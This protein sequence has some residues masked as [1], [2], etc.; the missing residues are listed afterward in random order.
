[1]YRR[2]G[3]H[4]SP[5]VEGLDILQSS[6]LASLGFIAFTYFYDEYRYSRITLL[7]F[8]LLHPWFVIAGRS[9]IRK[10]LRFYRRHAPPRSVL[11]I[12]SGEPLKRA[13]SLSDGVDLARGII[14]GVI[15]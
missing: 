9:G 3:R 2:T 7:L 6:I 13:L 12:G 11:I 15:P 1:L 4:R 10:A 5:F 8:A 14:T